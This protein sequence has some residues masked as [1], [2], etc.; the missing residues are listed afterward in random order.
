MRLR[1]IACV[2]SVGFQRHVRA[3]DRC[4]G[5]ER[6]AVRHGREAEVRHRE[7]PRD[8]APQQQVPGGAQHDVHGDFPTVLGFEMQNAIKTW[9]LPLISLIY[10]E[11]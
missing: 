9:N 4:D 2:S 8:H 6:E 3:E 1:Q 5:G 7:L 11:K 10:I